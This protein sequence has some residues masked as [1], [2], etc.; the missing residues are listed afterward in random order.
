MSAAV[1]TSG[2][3]G[4]AV[5]ATAGQSTAALPSSKPISAAD[6][7]FVATVA[8]G[9]SLE[10]EASKLA[11][12]RSRNDAVRKF[13][14][15]MVADHGKV[16]EE[17]RALPVAAS[18]GNF[19]ALMPKHKD[20]LSKLRELQGAAFDKAYVT[21]IGVAAHQETVSL[22]QK[23]ADGASDS[24]TKAFAQAKLPALREHLQMA[25]TMAQQVGGAAPPAK[26][27]AQADTGAAARAS[28]RSSRPGTQFA[29]ARNARRAAARTWA[30]LTACAHSCAVGQS[31][32]PQGRHGT[33]AHNTSCRS[34]RKRRPARH[35]GAGA[36]H[37]AAR[38]D[39]S[40]DVRD[41]G[42]VGD[43]E[44]SLAHQRA[45]LP[46]RA[47]AAEVDD[48]RAAARQ[49]ARQR[50]FALAAG[51]HQRPAVVHQRIG[52]LAEALDRPAARWQLR[53]RMKAHEAPP[54]HGVEH[55]LDRLLVAAHERKLELEAAAFD[56]E[57]VGQREQALDLVSLAR[58]AAV[59]SGLRTEILMLRKRRRA[60]RAEGRHQRIDH[61]A[62][63]VQ[64]DR[65]IE[66][67][68]LDLGEEAGQ[69]IDRRRH[70]GQNRESRE[71]R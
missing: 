69:R 23:A 1:P 55:V 54:C 4:A 68:R 26:A 29:A 60:P 28:R 52:D 11:L 12:E 63:A 42:V 15:H 17:L 27:A 43:H 58:E 64:L 56:A 66:L 44:P 9:N 41:A 3:R 47:A 45:E 46:Q 5:S 67:A 18:V 32:W 48:A 61:A 10:V 16:G 24:Q 25:Q 70:F 57:R 53:A 19:A 62:A 34:L 40:G 2:T 31:R 33:S 21:Q 22:F 8:S 59:E 30:L 71:R 49:L 6:V 7:D 50:R 14:Q 35:V 20:Q 65:E 13:A 38:A 39:R 37:H 36:H 51:D